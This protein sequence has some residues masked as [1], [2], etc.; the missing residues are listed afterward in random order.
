MP[1]HR[2]YLRIPL[3]V[4]VIA[5]SLAA[6]AA[7]GG[8]GTTDSV[9]ALPNS[10]SAVAPIPNAV[11]TGGSLEISVRAQS[12]F[13]LLNGTFVITTRSG[14]Q[15]TASYVGAVTA[16]IAGRPTVTL[17]FVIT[18]GS[19]VF[20][21]ASGTLQGKGSGAFTGAGDFV[22]PSVTGVLFTTA[23]PAGSLF[24]ATVVGTSALSCS[25]AHRM[26][27]TLRGQGTVAG[28]GR[29]DAELIGEIGN[30]GCIS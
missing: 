24:R 29:V 9:N 5:I 3:A 20:Q 26:L 1:R 19:G 30:T 27:L 21:G 22:L 16:P 4:L 23:N 13:P 8:P 12:S 11:L 25:A 14:D 2:V 6:A 7:C 18:G 15:L 10:P 17:E 28:V